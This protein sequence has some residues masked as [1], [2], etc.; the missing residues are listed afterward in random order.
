V[1]TDEKY[2]ASSSVRGTANVHLGELLHIL[3]YAKHASQ[4]ASYAAHAPPAVL[5]VAA[6]EHTS[7]LACTSTACAPIYTANVSCQHWYQLLPLLLITITAASANAV[8][9]AAMLLLF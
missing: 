3:P 2:N 5:P 9:T 4:T 6:V 1:L 7:L 8:T